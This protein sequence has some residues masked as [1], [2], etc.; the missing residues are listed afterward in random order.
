LD[1][2]GEIGVLQYLYNLGG[3]GERNTITRERG[4]MV[5]AL[6]GVIVKKREKVSS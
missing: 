3:R 2:E 6:G 1:H 5:A 4:R